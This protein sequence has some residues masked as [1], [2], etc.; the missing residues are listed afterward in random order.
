MR[1]MWPQVLAA[2]LCLSTAELPLW[3]QQAA[4]APQKPGEP[5]I[6]RPYFSEYIPPVRTRNSLRL[7]DLIRAGKLYLTAQDAIAMAIENNID[8]EI[9][10]Y[11]PLIQE[12]QLR[13]QQAGGALAGIPSAASRIGT[14]QSGQGVA[15]SQQAAGVSGGQNGQSNNTANATV[16][17]IGSVT[18]VLDPIFQQVQTY[19]HR[20]SPQPLQRQSQTS[21]LISNTRN[22]Q[23]AIQQGL[24]TGGQATLTYADSYLNENAPS[25]LL[26]PSNGV[27]AQL[28]VQHNF[29]RGFGIA[30]N[31]R[32]ITIAK[33]NLALSGTQF[34]AQ[35]IAVVANVLNL[36]Y[37]LVADY[38]DLK[39]K[40]SA[41]EVA[42]RFFENNKKQVQIGSMAPLDITTAEA[43]L[44]TSQQELVVSQTTLA[45]QQVALKNVLSRTGLADPVLR[46]VDIIPLDP[47]IVPEKA[48]V[49]PKKELLAKALANRTD[50]AADRVNLENARVNSLNTQNSVLPQLAGVV[51]A[52][53]QGLNG[54]PQASPIRGGGQVSAG[55]GSVPGIIPCPP[56]IGQPGQA[57]QVPDPY[58]VGGIGTGL[59]QMIRR[60]FPSQRATAFFNASLRNR[61]AQADNNIDQLSLRQTELE[62][63]RSVNE[64]AVTVSNS[65]IGLQQARVRYQAALRNR[66][67]SQQLLDAE[68]KKFSLGVSTTFEVVQQQRD[69]A[70]AQSNEV[71]ALAAYSNAR[72]AL[73]QTVGLTLEQNHI[74]VTEALDGHL[75]RKSVLPDQLPSQP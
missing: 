25:N 61:S 12:S 43:Q 3:A 17:Q 40:T 71:A 34:K 23:T 16:T 49:F 29:L 62:N 41:V 30:V 21:N 56:G 66:I 69:L 42:Q 68:Q 63:A 7:Q 28:Q 24:I 50:I 18:P 57:C 73:D 20:S 22:Y 51:S 19:S 74:A 1:R 55:S 67:L 5:V 9:A 64:I 10:R 13:R 65:I 53:N 2:V 33:A 48:E 6:I 4:I 70:T 52:T 58:F 31:S 46:T 15:G 14:V 38:A 37:G 8:I 45:Q 26:N 72:V 54:S 35:V 75:P 60:N 32:N 44:A 59:G 27:S 36:Y 11:N 47:I 39:A